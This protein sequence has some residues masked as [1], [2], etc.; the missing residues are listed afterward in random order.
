LNANSSEA[1]HWHALLLMILDRFPQAIQEIKLAQILDPVS[2]I[3]NTNEGWLYYHHRQ[4]DQAEAKLKAVLEMDPDFVS[5][6]IKWG[7]V[8]QQTG[9]QKEAIAVF[10][11]VCAKLQNDLT[12]RA[13]LGYALALAGEK[14]KARKILS[15]IIDLAHLKYV[16]PYFI[17]CIY[18]ALGD[19]ESAWHWLEK[20]YEQRSGWL[21]WFAHDPKMD[22]LHDDLRFAKM[23]KKIGLPDVTLH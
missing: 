3:I 1:H 10:D 11:H 20:A 16:S 22:P 18:V 21:T 8:L 19:N 5:A 9:G 17:A 6:L 2:L 4:Y 13:M 12:V 15:E 23:V 7:W 14:E